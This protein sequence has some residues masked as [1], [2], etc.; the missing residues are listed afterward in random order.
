MPRRSGYGKGI[1]M[2]AKTTWILVANGTQAFI[3][4]N[5]GPG[6]GLEK[7]LEHEFEGPNLANREIMADAPGRSFDSAGRGRHSMEP[8]SDPRR[9]NQQV[10]AHDIAQYLGAAA[11]RHAF[12]RLVLVAAPQ[13]LGDLRKCLPESAR[14]KVTSEL[15][16]D[17]VH[18]PLHKLSDHLGDVVAL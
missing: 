11:E 5:L 16:K 9:H 18:V 15:A 14:A 4:C 2:K 6:H 17:L 8:H 7:S 3:A 1:H 12:E 10:F 13:M